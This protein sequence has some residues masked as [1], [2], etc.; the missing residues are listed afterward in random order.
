[1][2]KFTKVMRNLALLTLGMLFSFAM[3]MAQERTISGRV[4][5]GGEPLPGV[6]IF[7]QGTTVGTISDL[8]GSYKLTVPG[9]DAI[10]I[11]SSIG[12]KTQQVTVGNQTTIDITLEEDVTALGEV[13]VT[14]YTIDTKRETVGAISSIKPQDL[15][16]I[17][18]GNVEQ[19]LQGR[20]AGV[21]VVTNGQPGT[22]SQIRVRGFG[23]FGGNAPLYIVDGVPTTT[24]EFLNPDDIETTTI[25]KDASTASIYGSRAANGVIVYTTRRGA[26]NKGLQVHYDGMFG[27]TT[28][29]QGQQM[30]NPQDFAEWTWKMFDNTALQNKTT[31]A[32]DHPQFGNGSQPVIPDYINV[33]GAAGVMGPLD[34]EAKGKDT[35][36]I[37]KEVRS[38]RW[39]L[40]TGREP[41]GTMKSQGLPRLCAI[42]LGCQAVVKTAAS[43][44]VSGFRIRMVFCF[45]RNS[46]GIHSGQIPSSAS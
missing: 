1:M 21:T 39:L 37:R 4:I 14:G 22:T 26:K 28:P 43:T 16:V 13:V 33:G 24:T 27:F 3:V 40:P 44:L 10:L 11:F 30:M 2:R 9:P 36:W 46:K 5:A 45:T 35:M 31:P 32:Y 25:L 42:R 20:A 23:S 7:I 12:Y 29:G 8:D 41:T 19:Q 6:N 18:S 38:T 34:L 15:T 17:P